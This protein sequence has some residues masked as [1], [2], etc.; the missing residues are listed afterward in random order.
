A[1]PIEVPF[2][3][4]EPGIGYDP[5]VRSWNFPNPWPGGAWSVRD[6][7]NDQGAATRAILVHAA[8]NREYWLRT[9]YEVNR[10]A[11]ERREPFAFVI[12]RTQTRSGERRVAKERRSPWS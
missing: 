4:L 5:R 3:N 8:R 2:E 10:R 9:F 12:P 1:T 6:I 7:M 11:A